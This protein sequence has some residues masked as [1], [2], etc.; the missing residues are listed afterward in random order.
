MVDTKEISITEKETESVCISILSSESAGIYCEYNLQL[1][2]ISLGWQEEKGFCPK[3]CLNLNLQIVEKVDNTG[4]LD[5][6]RPDQIVVEETNLDEI[7]EQ[8]E[9]EHSL[10]LVLKASA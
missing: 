6:G 4:F 9:S 3:E 8:K 2:V 10:F 7:K 5:D 1:E